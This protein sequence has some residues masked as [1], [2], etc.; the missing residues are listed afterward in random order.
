MMDDWPRRG[1]AYQSGVGTFS[2][3]PDESLWTKWFTGVALPAGC[4]AYAGV[5]LFRQRVTVPWAEGHLSFGTRWSEL[6]GWGLAFFTALMIGVAAC[7][8]TH[9][10]WGQRYATDHPVT[11][12]GLLFGMVVGLTGA[13]GLIA[14]AVLPM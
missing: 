5:G 12:L 7:L 1:E 14:R 4:L 2:S 11:H 10:F 13:F 9:A 3:G 8:H 6:E